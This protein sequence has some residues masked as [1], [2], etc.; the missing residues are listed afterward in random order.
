MSHAESG[1]TGPTVSAHASPYR[2]LLHLNF[3]IRELPFGLVLILTLIGVAYTSFSKK[4]ITGYWEFLAPL[5]ALVCVGA[6]WQAPT[7]MPSACG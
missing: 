2:H 3:W 1:P 6:G 7:T 4:P 5:L